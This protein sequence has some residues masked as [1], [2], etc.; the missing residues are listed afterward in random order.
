MAS[1][2]PRP[3]RLQP[4]ISKPVAATQLP[5]TRTV[6][7][8]HGLRR[9]TAN[10]ATRATSTKVTAAM[11]ASPN[12]SRS[13]AAMAAPLSQPYVGRPTHLPVSRPYATAKH[14]GV[15]LATVYSLVTNRHLHCVRISNA[16]RIHPGDVAAYMAP[17]RE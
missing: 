3:L 13:A 17:R 9:E 2:Q 11:P 5:A 7:R 8:I 15:S 12:A 6:I 10:A 14:L 16:I 4:S 1:N